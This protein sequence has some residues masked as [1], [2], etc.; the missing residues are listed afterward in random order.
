MKQYS[1]LVAFSSTGALLARYRKT[2]L[3]F[4]P[5]F[6]PPEDQPITSAWFDT[7]FGVRFGMMICFDIMFYTPGV[8]IA[9]NLTVGVKDFVY[10]SWWVNSA[11]PLLTGTQVH[12]SCFFIYFL[13]YFI[14]FILYY[15]FYFFFAFFLLV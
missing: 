10:S 9:T 6:D 11:G 7:P 3:Y 4:E 8:Q 13:F 15:Y 1:A 12:L 5:H 14:Y 2:N